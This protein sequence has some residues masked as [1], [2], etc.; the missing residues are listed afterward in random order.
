VRDGSPGWPAT[1]AAD[2]AARGGLDDALVRDA[3]AH[4]VGL[5][6]VAA[7]GAV[8]WSDEA[9]RL[10]GRP[11][12]RRVR[13]LDDLDW[14]VDDDEAVRRTYTKALDDPDVEL[15]Y[16]AVGERGETRELVLRAIDRGVA[17]V[18][19]AGARGIVEPPPPRAPRTV[20]DVPTPDDEEPPRGRLR[21]AGELDDELG[22][23]LVDGAAPDDV[24][25][26]HDEAGAT[27]ELEPEPAFSPEPV[28]DA[29]TST[30]GPGG[31][32]GATAHD[33]ASAVLNASPDLVLLYDLDTNHVVNMAGNEADAPELVAHLASGGMIRDKVHPD[34]LATLLQA[35]EDFTSLTDGEVRHVDARFAVGDSWQWREIRASA[36]RRDRDGS[37]REAVLL[38]RDVNERVEATLRLTE[39]ER[40]FREVFDASPIGLA[41][42]DGHGRFTDVNDS[43]CRLAGRTRD[44][45]LD[46]SYVALLHPKDRAAAE[47]SRA[48]RLSDEPPSAPADRRLVRADGAV[49]WVRVRSSGIDVGDS[50]R[51]LLS[52]E[53][54][55]G[56][57]E[58]E[59]QLRHDALHDELTG[60]PNRRLLMDR[61][62]R[63]LVRARRSSTR[64]AI[65]FVDLD[66]LKKVNDTHPWKHRAGDVLITTTTA[67]VRETLREA[68]TL[69]RLG[70]DEFVA[71]CEDV[72]DDDIVDEIGDRILLAAT[73]KQT[74]GTE[75]IMP[76]ASIGVA[77][78]DDADE[79][80]EALL[81]RAD[82]AMYRAKSEGGSR[83]ARADDTGRASTLSVDLASALARGELSQ[84]YQP[85]VS[86]STGAVLGVTTVL[87][88]RDPARGL[89][90]NSE[91]RTALE[92][93]AAATPVVHWSIANAVADVRTVAP[94]RVEHVS[95]WLPIP[96][97]AALASSTKEA[98][99][100]AIRGADGSGDTDSAPSIV[101]DVHERDVATL[102]RRLGPHEQL[103]E[104][105]ESGPL[106]LGVDHFTASTVPLGMLQQLSAA[107]VS[108]DPLL[109]ADAA[110]NPS[111]AEV[112][113]ALVTASGALGVVSIAMDI[114][115]HEQLDLARALGV[116]AVYGDL[117]GPPAPLDT[118]S[119]LLHG[120][121][122]VLP[123]VADEWDEE[124]EIADVGPEADLEP[125]EHP[126]APT[127]MDAP[128]SGPFRP[129]PPVEGVTD[130][131]DD[132]WAALIA[133]S[134]GQASQRSEPE[135]QAPEVHA[136]PEQGPSVLPDPVAEV[137]P[138]VEARPVVVPD[139]VAEP[140]AVAWPVPV[141]DQAEPDTSPSAGAVPEPV[142]WPVVV[143]DIPAV[144]TPV[145]G[146]QS[147]PLPG[148]APA[149]ATP[150]VPAP[151]PAAPVAGAPSVPASGAPHVGVGDAL[152]AELGYTW[153]AMAPP[154]GPAYRTESPVWDALAQR[155]P[156]LDESPVWAELLRRSREAGGPGT[157]ST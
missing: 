27:G 61:L 21:K 134:L 131:S 98:V 4:Q 33:L 50:V 114:E 146:S 39:S 101:L 149:P 16:V 65:F 71:I 41:V 69:G 19:R 119:D 36:F 9:Y 73:H 76:G 105:L 127:A 56:A 156:E 57:K 97:R 14:G 68:D 83:V 32:R 12:W 151:A 147:W 128:S 8:W 102:T 18:H 87:R 66:D 22:D 89:L 100:A 53:D 55:S 103:D 38:V 95:V 145:P 46:T 35:R 90:P 136:A 62:E 120:G 48:R 67:A 25:T 142:G 117:I 45:I 6:T 140:S 54:V 42:L 72:S 49:M 148:A 115:S 81:R 20:V 74:I 144:A 99:E 152:A 125:E 139:P 40:A 60:L 116:H 92:T 85:I 13:T 15:R 37:L 141:G 30:A 124:P 23:D 7:D 111:T 59:D 10:H 130:V 137:A 17:V 122:V 133:G 26:P 123:T 82:T 93:S 153:A 11:R 52:F 96:A 86:L 43:F 121:R 24:A 51:T 3:T 150:P 88:W 64:V 110:R 29:G 79:T 143:R 80:A 77:V 132:A 1:V 108:L 157:S 155:Y 113:H 135:Q 44:A 31:D 138:A 94:T 84:H 2:Y 106:A 75:T 107:S 63:A 104:L 118:Y 91:V 129:G 154:P 112:V 78:S 109:L 34:D 126:D 28:A 58:T 5:V 47:I 70:G